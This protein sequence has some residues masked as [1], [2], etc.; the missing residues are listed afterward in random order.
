MLARFHMLN[1]LMW[2]VATKLDGPNTGH[3]PVWS[4]GLA[5]GVRG[6]G[7]SP[8]GLSLSTGCEALQRALNLSEVYFYFFISKMRTT[9]LPHSEGPMR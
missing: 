7:Q 1:N 8:W 5:D 9:G 4:A 3:F 6:V 2:L